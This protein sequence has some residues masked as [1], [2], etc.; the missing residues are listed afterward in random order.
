MAMTE[1][2]G[3]SEMWEKDRRAVMARQT[4]GH[5]ASAEGLYYHTL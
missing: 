2:N 3:A 1:T 5:G 4:P